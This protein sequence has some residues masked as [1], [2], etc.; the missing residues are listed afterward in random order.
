M[1]FL[2]YKLRRLRQLKGWSMTQTEK[3]TGVK[4]S[5]LS[6]LENG[7]SDTP[8]T[9][10]VDKLCHGFGVTREYFYIADQTVPPEFL[11]PLPDSLLE[12]IV[13]DPEAPAYLGAALRAKIAGIRADT[14]EKII[15]ALIEQQ[16]A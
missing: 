13:R 12:F 5:T 10:T 9:S 11:P 7:E 8:R 14:L 6:D 4:Q 3:L 1:S 16:Q 15:D 2:G